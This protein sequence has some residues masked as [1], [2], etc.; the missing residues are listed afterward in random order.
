MPQSKL[1]IVADVGG[2][3]ITSTLTREADGQLGHGPITLPAAEAGALTT[4]TD[5]DTGTITIEDHGF[6][7]GDIVDVYWDG[8][9]RF[10]MAVSS[11]AAD[12]FVVGASVVGAGDNLPAQDTAVIVCKQTVIDSDFD[13][14]K[15]VAI[16]AKLSARGHM[17]IRDDSDVHAVSVDLA[18]GEVW[19]WTDALAGANPLAG[20]L[21]GS[22][23]IS[24]ASLSPATFAFGL[25]YDSTV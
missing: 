10:G 1:R 24:H 23:A 16:A 15:V 5:N 2:I 21:V 8:G 13:G 25:L 18:A 9:R 7:D 4:R 11:A 20:E 12:T 3:S 6:E 14:D 19:H 17:S 22:L